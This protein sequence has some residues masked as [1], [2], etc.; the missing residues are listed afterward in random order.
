MRPPN[1]V[2]LAMATLALMILV[3]LQT[4]HR[5]KAVAAQAIPT[6]STATIAPS[7]APSACADVIGPRA[8]MRIH[9]PREKE[10]EEGGRTLRLGTYLSESDAKQAQT[11]FG[12]YIT[13]CVTSSLTSDWAWWCH[14]DLLKRT[15]I[16]KDDKRWQLYLNN[17]T[18]PEAMNLCA[19]LWVSP[20]MLEVPWAR[21]VKDGAGN[22]CV[23]RN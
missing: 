22:T 6:H 11:E 10:L 19:F 18:V 9:F 1:V 13:K 21:R 12:Q 7:A 2:F 8:I 20:E 5:H 23:F 15:K 3:V 4:N 14:L 17:L 16:E